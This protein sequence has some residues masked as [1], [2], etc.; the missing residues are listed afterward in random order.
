[1]QVEPKL[2]LECETVEKGR[3]VFGHRMIQST[4]SNLLG[5]RGPVFVAFI[6]AKGL[7]RI[8]LGLVGQSL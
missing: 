8:L 1:M 3:P 2:V 5:S 6:K 4:F 7:I